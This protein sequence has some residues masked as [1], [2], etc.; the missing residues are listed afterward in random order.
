MKHS[1]VVVRTLRDYINQ[2]LN[3]VTNQSVNSLLTIM[4]Q[5][6]RE[7]GSSF[8]HLFRLERSKRVVQ[9]NTRGRERGHK[10]ECYCGWDGQPTTIGRR[11]T[12][13]IRCLMRYIET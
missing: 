8:A 9:L 5:C 10:S 1:L 3:V 12:G 4:I 13:I 7:I 6:Y 11:L 2:Q